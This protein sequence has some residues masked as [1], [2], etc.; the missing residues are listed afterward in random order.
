MRHGY[1]RGSKQLGFPTANLPDFS[2]QLAGV[3]Q[4]IYCGWCR[5]EDDD[6]DDQIRPCV[7][8]IGYSPTFKEQNPH[9]IMET[10]IIDRPTAD[11]SE[12]GQLATFYGKYM[13][14]LLVEYL[15]PEEQFASL[16]QLIAQ[17]HQD[18]ATAR[19]CTRAR[20]KSRM[21]SMDE[22]GRLLGSLDANGDADAVGQKLVLVDT[23]Y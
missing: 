13:R 6:I 3:E 5:V 7:T 12:D 8:N 1:G 22:V 2:T 14:I 18:V 10:F 20:V 4:G 21:P 19:E 15:R 11:A 16:D 17:M 23:E 9:L